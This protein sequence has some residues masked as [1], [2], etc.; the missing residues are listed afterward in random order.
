MQGTELLVHCKS[1][2]LLLA[3]F[4]G[5]VIAYPQRYPNSE[6]NKLLDIGIEYITNQ[7]YDLA[8]SKFELLEKNYP[9]LP[10]GKIYLAVVQISKAF[11]YGIEIEADSVEKK[12]NDALEESELL[13]EKDPS[14]V[15]NHYFA[16][17]SKGYKAYYHVLNENWIAAISNGMSSEGYFE[18]CLEIDSS[19]VESYV[20]IGTFK[21][22]K[23]RKLEFLEWLP[24]M[25]DDS[26]IGI[27]YLETA[28]KNSTY[29]RN[30]A[31][32]SLIWIYI[33]TGS[34]KRAIEIAEKELKN[35]PLNRA[36]KWALG[37]AYEDVNTNRSIEIYKELISSYRK[38]AH[39]N[40]FQELTLKH[41]LAQQY[42]KIGEKREALRVCHEILSMHNLEENV[43]KK[44]SDRFK[45][46]KELKR[47]LSK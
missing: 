9:E 31:A 32:I 46:V 12:L 16:A 18:D 44:L 26:K 23:S 41:I 3:L 47:E 43:L 14:N 38:I 45:K 24:F 6:V 21:F 36:L 11:D 17:L 10:L 40:H 20:A 13:I 5:N 39:Q 30:L 15:W 1:S 28:L 7:N 25:N 27:D 19:F 37:R 29:N 22:W 8:K 4:I 2:L 34:F 35:H 42:V 33:E